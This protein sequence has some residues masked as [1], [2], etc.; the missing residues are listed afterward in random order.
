SHGLRPTTSPPTSSVSRVAISASGSKTAMPTTP[1]RSSGGYAYFTEAWSMR[2]YH[3]G[4]NWK[5]LTRFETKF[6]YFGLNIDTHGSG[7]V[8]IDVQPEVRELRLEA[9]QGLPVQSAVVLPHRP[10]LGEVGVAATRAAGRS[11]H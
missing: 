10:G 9:S 6:T 5:P 11:R 4:L 8:G 2:K 1:C 3:C 7:A